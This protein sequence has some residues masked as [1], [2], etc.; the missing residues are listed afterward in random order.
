MSHG[1]IYTGPSGQPLHGDGTPVRQEKTTT[2]KIEFV[3]C[4]VLFPHVREIGGQTMMLEPLFSGNVALPNDDD[5]KKCIER[6]WLKTVSE[7][8]M[9]EPAYDPTK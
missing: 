2:M 4:N 3:I 1:G 8:F 5:T 7:P 6:G 9:A